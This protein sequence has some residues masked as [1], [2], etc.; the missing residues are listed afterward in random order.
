MRK[1]P[2][3]G[4]TSFGSG[5]NPVAALCDQNYSKLLSQAKEQQDRAG[6]SGA[7]SS[8]I[9]EKSPVINTDNLAAMIRWTQESQKQAELVDPDLLGGK[10]VHPERR[11]ESSTSI[12]WTV[13]AAQHERCNIPDSH[14]GA[15][16]ISSFDNKQKDLAAQPGSP[17]PQANAEVAPPLRPDEAAEFSQEEEDYVNSFFCDSSA[18][19]VPPPPPSIAR[20]KN[21][22]KAVFDTADEFV[23]ESVDHCSGLKKAA[24]VSAASPRPT[25]GVQPGRRDGVTTSAAPEVGVVVPLGEDDL[26][27]LMRS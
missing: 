20:Q 19:G 9:P 4:C 16:A 3:S 22:P 8:K 24:V 1:R 18:V 15:A 7:F 25:R 11:Q 23:P 14:T 5:D 17:K 26:R 6:R 2:I 21:A 10:V 12:D 27:H 13:G